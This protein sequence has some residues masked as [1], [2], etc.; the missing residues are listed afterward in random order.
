MIKL[1]IKKLSNSIGILLKLF[2]I[3]K[4][5]KISF[6]FFK[7][8]ISFFKVSKEISLMVSPVRTVIERDKSSRLYPFEII[9]SFIYF[10]FSEF[11]RHLKKRHFLI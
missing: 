3:F 11:V 5:F 6:S 1:K 2:L 10:C 7:N 9:L 8:S 4:F